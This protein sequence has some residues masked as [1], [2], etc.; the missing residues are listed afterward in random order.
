MSVKEVH[1]KLV[2]NMKK[3]QKLEDATILQTSEI[4]SKTDN[5][6]IRIIMEII[7]S[8]SLNH[9]RVQSL[10]SETIERGI[11]VNPDELMEIWGLIERHREM[12]KKY[13]QIGS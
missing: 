2:S 9:H 13:C 4:I 5:P 1:E 7:R 10:I 12:E 3:W 11:T 6:V 8:D